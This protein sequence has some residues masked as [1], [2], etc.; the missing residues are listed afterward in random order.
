[1]EE[2]HGREVDEFGGTRDSLALN[3]IPSYLYHKALSLRPIHFHHTKLRY[4]ASSTP[5][6]VIKR[7]HVCHSACFGYKDIKE[8][9]LII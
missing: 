9:S 7:D 4:T 2:L 3:M 1:M 8:D 6:N 5:R